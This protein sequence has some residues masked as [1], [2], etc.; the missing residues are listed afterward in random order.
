MIHDHAGSWS[1][2]LAARLAYHSAVTTIRLARAVQ[3]RGITLIRRVYE[4]A[5]PGC[6]N[7]GLG[8]PADPV[9]DAA[10]AAARAALEKRVV[11]YTPTAGLPELRAALAEKAYGDRAE[12][13]LVTSGSQEALW[14]TLMGLVNPGEDVLFA[15]PGYPA[16]RMVTEMIGARAVTVRTRLED[17]WRLDPDAVAAAWTAGTRALIVGSPGNPTGCFAQD[18]AGMERL[19]RLCVERDAWFIAD[20]IYAPI[21]F[22]R[23]H[24]PLHVLGDRVVAIGGMSKAWSGTG[25][26]IGWIHALPELLHGV[27]P[28]HQQVALCAPTI[29]QHAALACMPAWGEPLEREL[30]E[31]YGPRRRAMLESIARMPDARVHEPDGAFYAFVDVSRHAQ[32]T[33][34]LAL[35]LRDEAK[36]I[37]APGEAFGAM[38]GYL[39]LSFVADPDVI[40]EG[41]GRIAA[42]LE[43]ESGAAR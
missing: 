17:G 13:V 14:V 15:E 2:C 1:G 32:D 9:P 8:Q 7:L 40:R 26:R 16:Y 28:L 43:R 35:R 36:V 29:G 3:G 27:M 42:F 39:R 24:E 34:A 23:P 21:R 11:A 4:G 25:F 10:L 33:L 30:A 22:A 19:Y 5:P 38:A 12:S 20:E 31:R 6:I 37:T 41:V 18:Q